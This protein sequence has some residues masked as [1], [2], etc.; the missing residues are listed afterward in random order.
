M[1]DR[2]N[3]TPKQPH[4]PSRRSFLQGVAGGTIGAAGLV[5]AGY[6]V[7]R[8]TGDV[9]PRDL[10]RPRPAQGRQIELTVNGK[11]VDVTVADQRTLLLALRED[12]GL[13]G[14]KKGCNMGQ[15]GA[16]TVLMDGEPVYSCFTLA[17]D[18]VGHEI[19]TI[20]GL[21]KNGK[22][23]PVQQGFIDNMGSQCGMCS[24]GMIMCGAALLERNPSP[25]PEEVRFAISGVLCR[26]GNY[27][28]EVAG[29]LAAAGQGGA[30]AEGAA[31]PAASGLLAPFPDVTRSPG[32]R[33]EKVADSADLAR[34]DTQG[35]ALDGHAKATGRARYAGDLGFRP[36]DAF[37]KPLFAKVVRSP[38][39]HARVTG[40]D[41]SAARQLDG[42]RG[43][44]TWEDVPDYGNDRK[45]LNRHARYV[46]DAVAALAADDQYTAQEALDL[47]RVE[48]EIL[49]VYAD[50]EENLRTGN[51]AIHEGG[52]VAS[53]SGPRGA[54]EPTV[55]RSDGDGDPEEALAAADH[56]VEGRYET[57]LQCHV[58][59]EPHCCTA[60]WKDDRLSVWDTQQSVFAAQDQ[61]ARVLGLEAE[62]VRVSCDN[63]GGGFGGKCTDTPG[64]TL[65]Q[66]IAATLAQ[67]TG[68]PVR[69][70]YTL[71]ELAAAEDTRTKF[72]F[73]IRTGMTKDGTLTAFDCRAVLDNGAYASSG[74]AVNS[75]AASAMFNSIKTPASRYTGYSVYTNRPV[76]GEMRGFGGPSGSYAL[77]LHMDKCAEAL[78]MDPIEFMR[79]NWKSPG[80]T[81]TQEGVSGVTVGNNR[82]ND[83]VRLAAEAIG[84]KDRRPPSEKSGRIRRGLGMY[85][86]AQ[87][88]GRA[89]SDGLIWLDPQGRLHMP[90]GTGN[91]GTAA[92]TGL[93]A[94]AAE[95]LDVP[96]DAIDVT[97][98]DTDSVAW[99]F[100]T[101]ASR[102]SNCDG[103]AV[104]NAARDLL[105]QMTAQ[106]A[107]ALDVAEDDIAVRNG[108]IEGPDGAQ[109]D[110]RALAAQ[111]PARDDFK[112]YFDPETDQN[113]L[114]DEATGKVD[115]NPP[116][117]V[118]PATRALAERML[119]K[120]GIVGLGHFVWNPS[121]QAWG[122][123]FAEVEV[124]TETGQVRVLRLVNSH[125]LGRILYRTG[126]EAQVY[127]GAIMG[128]GYGL[129]EGLAIDPNSQV[130]VAP[131]F[132]GLQPMTA[133]DYPEITPILIEAPGEGGPF[134]AKG[135]GE[136]PIFGPAPAV[137]NAV[138]N[139]TGVRIDE[140]PL[141][142][143][144]VYNGLRR[145]GI[146]A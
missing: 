87:H 117:E 47:I 119:K 125:D 83:T 110:F 33:V 58:P 69:L 78:G 135:F 23:H 52:P 95:V 57:G 34:F 13:T 128:L 9:T 46:G 103:K 65:Y 35:P 97:W 99:T 76:G 113:P 75:T 3:P 42:Y 26:C 91:L 134:G 105:R 66:A 4:G 10:A 54:D 67:K 120:G 84:W 89:D 111:A 116:M 60:V 126:A 56:V 102:S 129:T 139:A 22:L 112:P 72:T 8:D 114:L 106:A 142:W 124:D 51:T 80:D 6:V 109:I 45:F 118:K 1:T 64:K 86:G 81:E 11:T 85:T 55:S 90:I 18:A 94:I 53:L 20:E 133:L 44:I 104:M 21:E 100:V 138:Y 73:H 115:D 108:R 16:C 82:Q 137:A 15:C 17:K 88:S 63:V 101:D 74:P 70:E 77:A 107:A 132:L 121:A 41:D 24:S 31:I 37:R 79:K 49:P 71:E 122:S 96:T 127:G 141:T 5:G 145:A 30:A 28:H 140:I 93:A 12:L 98:G 29:I 25:S 92:H 59:I 143:D 19:T 27:P 39:P 40:I 32:A 48:W 7:A 61:I 43:L 62:N 38:H 144:V 146:S 130:P 14:T 36:D 50:A 2:R 68:E 136:N 123:S 131:S